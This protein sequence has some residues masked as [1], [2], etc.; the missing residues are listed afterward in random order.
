VWVWGGGGM[1]WLHIPRESHLHSEPHEEHL[2]TT[3]KSAT[4]PREA[5]QG[6]SGCSE[7]MCSAHPACQSTRQ[8]IVT[9]VFKPGNRPHVNLELKYVHREPEF[10]RYPAETLDKP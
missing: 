8:S 1:Q 10:P 6:A 3:A 5:S 2:P 7:R 4:A 9:G